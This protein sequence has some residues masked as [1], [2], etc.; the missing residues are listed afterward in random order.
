L[1]AV[2]NAAPSS[3]R[4]KAVKVAIFVSSAIILLA[5]AIALLVRLTGYWK[6]LHVNILT[7]K[8]IWSASVPHGDFWSRRKTAHTD[9]RGFSEEMMPIAQLASGS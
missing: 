1:I 2:G 9:R 8:G 4:S 6:I 3:P 5:A 7:S